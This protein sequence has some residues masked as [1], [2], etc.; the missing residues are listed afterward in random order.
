MGYPPPTLTNVNLLYVGRIDEN[1]NILNLLYQIEKFSINLNEFTIVGDGPL[2]KDLEYFALNNPK[3]R[4][5]GRLSNTETCKIMARNDYLILPSLYDGWGAVVNES[6][7]QGTP[8]MCSKSCGSSIL[9]DN[10]L[11]GYVFDNEN[12][13]SVIVSIC[14]KGRVQQERRN[15][16]KQWA[17]HC[18]SGQIAA[19]YFC[20]IMNGKERIA[21]WL[22]NKY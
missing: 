20:E 11:R 13:I 15:R 3:I 12:M 14:R 8:V 2:M 22:E 4:L 5:L 21:P 7:A 9:I 6:L 1:K 10:S 16:I 18:I 19:D 17:T